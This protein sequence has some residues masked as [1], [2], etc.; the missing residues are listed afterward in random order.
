MSSSNNSC[1]VEF[2]T[3][4]LLPVYLMYVSYPFDSPFSKAES[5]L[6]NEIQQRKETTCILLI[7]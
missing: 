6:A 7:H 5:K 2:K 4:K 3:E 1:V